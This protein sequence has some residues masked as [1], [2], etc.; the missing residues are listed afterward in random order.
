[1]RILI[2]NWRC[3]KHPWAGGAENYLHEIS[4]RLVKRGHQITWFASSWKGLKEREVSDGM[5]VIR[6][7]G[8]YSVYIHAFLTYITELRNEDF[9]VI[10]D[11]INGVPFFTPLFVRR[12][13][14]AVL[15]HLVRRIFFKELRFYLAFVGYFS[16]RLVPVAYRKTKFITVSKS[17][18]NELE[19]FGIKD[20]EVIYNGVDITIND[21]LDKSLN[22][23]IAFLGRLKRYKRLDHLL[24]A[25]R[26]VSVRIPETELWIAGD[27]DQGIELEKLAEEMG[28]TVDFLSHVD[29]ATKVKLLQEAWVFVTTSE[30]EGWGVTVLEANACGTPCIGYDVP[31]LRD[32]ILNGETGFLVSDG[33]FEELASMICK[34]LEDEILREKLSRNALEY[35]KRFSWDESALLFEM[36]LENSIKINNYNT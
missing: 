11:D 22:P 26:I 36:A 7:G 15:H 18:K 1:M 19:D 14:V 34:V 32:S 23:S 16:E 9:D 27:G 29:E 3:W 12:E 21:N 10:V 28:L 6:K 31:G 24:K 17:T 4:W 33:D 13:K 30:K 2:F 5:E 20:I 35:S 8:K 25:Y